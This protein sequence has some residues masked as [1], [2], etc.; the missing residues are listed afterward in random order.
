[1]QKIYRLSTLLLCMFILGSSCTKDSADE[2]NA[3][4][5]ILTN[6]FKGTETE[7][8]DEYSLRT[9]VEPY[10][11]AETEEM[12]I[13]CTD[14]E[15]NFVLT[16][17]SDGTV[18]KERP[19][20]GYQQ[21][22]NGVLTEDNLYSVS[23]MYDDTLREQT[24]HIV[25]YSLADGTY[26]VSEDVRAMFSQNG[27][28]FLLK[29]IAVD[30]DGNFCL[31]SEWEIVVTDSTFRKQFSAVV[32]EEISTL[33]ASADGDV[34]VTVKSSS[35]KP[36]LRKIERE[37][38]ELGELIRPPEN[39]HVK[40]YL[41]GDGYD[42]FLSAEDGLYGWNFGEKEAVFLLDYASSDMYANNI[43]AA[44]VVN[45]DRVILFER[46]PETQEFRPVIRLRSAD[47]DLSQEKILEIAYVYCE[48]D[49]S[50]AIAEFNRKNPGVRVVAN[51]YS[52]YNTTENPDGGNRK[53]INDILLGLCKPDLVTAYSPED[54]L[55]SQIYANG[56]YADLYPLMEADG[57]V[58]RDDLLG[59]IPR[60]FETDE[61]KLW[62]IG[63]SVS[64][65]TY[66]G[67]KK[68]LGDRTGWTLPEMID[69]A[70][71]LPEGTQL[72]YGLS[73]QVLLKNLLGWDGFR[74]FVDME[75]STCNFECE[76][77]LRF[78]E[79]LASLP[80]TR[81]EVVRDYDGLGEYDTELYLDGMVVLGMT[82]C[83]RIAD[84]CSA[85][86]SFGMSDMV[87]I[88]YPTEDG[89]TDGGM[90]EITPYVITS[91]CEY[92]D[93]AWD[94]V[95]FLLAPDEK[96]DDPMSDGFPVLKE[97]FMNLCEANYDSQFMYHDGR[98]AYVTPEAEALFPR[99]GVRIPFTEEDAQALFR[100]FNEDI[101]YPA[102][103]AVDREI[104]AIVNEEVSRY[105]AG[106]NSAEDCARI[107][108]SRVSIWLAEHQ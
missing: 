13:C 59:C 2:D 97:K 12:L 107:I 35:G 78:L 88:G 69:F 34:Y 33:T 21:P 51:D 60:T 76:D 98:L 7:L 93:E 6:V 37:A 26:T 44:K 36:V 48:Y 66:M 58:T 99:P 45:A 30:G 3:V 102:A 106:A 39:I 73:Q 54:V 62:A 85:K 105:L 11:D 18:V 31:A 83:G 46:D 100:W 67:T 23:T 32:P 79:F 57:T 65:Q 84:W 91:F 96:C 40:E 49:L 56:L 14:G 50:T 9:G 24:Y 92:P 47:I 63:H 55:T 71:S 74:L 5:A 101:G 43:D 1:M 52:Q 70:E 4:P 72:M 68:M 42:V 75:T 27:D 64:V 104:E 19:L 61:G 81:E 22:R 10:Y 108:Q 94:F 90:V 8:S 80:E 89:K 87:Y 17:G 53:L 41:F 29:R 25:T 38:E 16:I 28:G 77:F 20:D 103:E 15:N 82:A 86:A 95:E